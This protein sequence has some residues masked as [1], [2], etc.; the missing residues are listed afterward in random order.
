MQKADSEDLFDRTV[1]AAKENFNLKQ[2]RL[3]DLWNRGST[4]GRVDKLKFDWH[5]L[6]GFEG[7]CLEEDI[8]FIYKDLI[9]VGWNFT[10][11]RGDKYKRKETS[12]FLTRIYIFF[13]A[14][15]GVRTNQL[16]IYKSASQ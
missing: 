3:L 2:L 13:F 6:E 7:K 1:L 8:V 9:T 14:A 16:E 4:N 12:L 5:S 15:L 10:N 11:K